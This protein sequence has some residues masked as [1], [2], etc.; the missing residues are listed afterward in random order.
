M[1]EE[2]IYDIVFYMEFSLLA[3]CFIYSIIF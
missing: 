2:A 1:G 3:W